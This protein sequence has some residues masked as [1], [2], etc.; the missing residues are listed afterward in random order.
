MILLYRDGVGGPSKVPKVLDQEV[1][2]MIKTIH[3]HDK[4]YTPK[5]LYTL[6]DKRVSH[7]L[8]EK[9]NGNGYLNPAPG[10]VVDQGLVEK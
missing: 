6:V 7:R 9:D 10:T 1:G 3:A 5:I 2:E 8:C 4:D